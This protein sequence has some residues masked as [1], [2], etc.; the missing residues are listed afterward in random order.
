[1]FPASLSNADHLSP[2]ADASLVE[3]LDGNL[4]A[5]SK[6]T[7]NVSFGNAAI[8]KHQFASAGRADAQFVFFFTDGKPWKI[9]FDEECGDS[10]V[11][12]LRIDVGEHDKKICFDSVR[13]PQLAAVQNK[14]IA[15]I[16]SPARESECVA[17]G[18]RFRQR[19]SANHVFGESRKVFAF[20]V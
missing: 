17:A 9:A 15:F 2:D 6:L 7:Q 12:L 4:V 19:V 8:L 14:M 11:T 20:L 18:A 1:M 3:C 5:F 13:N 16:R 10:F